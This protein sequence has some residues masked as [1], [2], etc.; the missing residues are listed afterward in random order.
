VTEIPRLVIAGTSSGVG[1]TT[2]VVGL[3]A[4]LRR[5]GLRVQPFKVGPDYIDP[6]HHTAATGTP[7]RN[8]D[9]WMVPKDALVEL[10]S[11]ACRG[12]DLAVI[13]GVMGLFDGFSGR[14][15]TGSTAEI[16]K[17]LDSPVLLVMDVRSM[18]R[19]A[20][21]MALGY[22]RFD[23]DLKV[24]GFVLNNVGG[25]KHYRM[26]REA[27]EGSGI[28]RVFGYLPRDPELD[29]PERHLGLIPT[30]EQPLSE[31]HLEKLA[32]LIET[33]VDVDG[34][35]RAATGRGGE[36]ENGRKEPLTPSPPHPVS[37]SSLF[38]AVPVPRRA[39]I[40][41]ARDEAFNFYYQDNLDLLEAHGAELVYF[42]PLHDTALPKG[43]GALY[44]GGGFPEMHADVLAR[45]RSMLESIR[46]VVNEGLPV[47][48]ECGGLMYLSEGIVDEAGTKHPLVGAVP[49]WCSMEGKRLH[50][51]YVEVRSAVDTP[52]GPAGLVARGHEFHYCNWDGLDPSRGAYRVLNQGERAE[53]FSLDNVLASFV[54]VHFAA[55]STLAPA[56]V[57]AAELRVMSDE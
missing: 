34:L 38:P 16:A 53:G 6:S 17:L 26:V 35:L 14:D 2:V 43:A 3:L 15:E 7:S 55:N 37:P 48:G 25:E 9:S 33:H 41:V 44:L 11:R 22:S 49:G 56:F 21:A 39:V 42:S 20:A 40:A 29:I 8:L 1:K 45:N 27:I 30:P 50:L 51:G 57:A 36:G 32:N 52:L 19:S 23:P 54:H 4:A 47:Y 18:A 13:E 12:A 28:G 31:E 5:R 46:L 10:F 24:A